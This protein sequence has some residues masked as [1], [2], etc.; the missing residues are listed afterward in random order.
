MKRSL[1]HLKSTAILGL[2]LLSCYRH[3][4]RDAEGE[5]AGGSKGIFLYTV[6]LDK[7]GVW[8]HSGFS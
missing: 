6:G 5:E 7:D 3:F 8:E 1:Q 2:E 4:F